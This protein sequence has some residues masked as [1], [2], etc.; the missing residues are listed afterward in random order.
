MEESQAQFAQVPQVTQ[1]PQVPHH[2]NPIDRYRAE[3]V[4]AH[5]HIP[6]EHRYE[7]RSSY[8]HRPHEEHSSYEHRHRYQPAPPVYHTY[9]PN[10][11][12]RNDQRSYQPYPQQYRGRS[13]RGGR[14][15]DSRRSGDRNFV[16]DERKATWVARIEKTLDNIS[17]AEPSLH[18][19]H[20]W[21][22][23]FVNASLDYSNK[24]TRL[25][26]SPAM[27]ETF[28]RISND[29]I[30]ETESV[31]DIVTGSS[32]EVL[33]GAF[34]RALRLDEPDGSFARAAPLV[35]TRGCQGCRG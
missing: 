29:Y 7:E 9:Y 8:E 11:P 13:A 1:V 12:Q 19:H 34:A 26:S 23:H 10:Q 4:Y 25:F 5:E 15:H 14:S 6:Y 22:R 24:L 21:V 35:E 33:R 28:M 27:F 17:G 20:D 32:R 31:N 3:D 18:V 16:S 2:Q 30:G